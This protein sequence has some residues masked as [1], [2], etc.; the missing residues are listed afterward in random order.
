M[1][2]RQV[3][4]NVGEKGLSSADSALSS[5]LKANY[6]LPVYANHDTTVE[7]SPLAWIFG[8]KKMGDRLITVVAWKK[9]VYQEGFNSIS[10]EGSLKTSG[11]DVIFDSINAAAFVDTRM[12]KPG[13]PSAGKAGID[14]SRKK[15]ENS[16]IRVKRR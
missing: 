1:A 11:N 4:L 7:R 2:A 6:A 16:R 5:S 12:A 14:S 13:S 15:N 8:G 10:L 3:N 9:G